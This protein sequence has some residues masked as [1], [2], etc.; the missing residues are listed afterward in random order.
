MPY[1][2]GDMV[3][4]RPDIQA[5]YRYQSPTTG[6]MD[7]Y[8]NEEMANRFGDVAMIVMIM[9]SPFPGYRIRFI[10]E[11]YAN[12][13]AWTDDMLMPHKEISN[14]QAVGIMSLDKDY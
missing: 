12:P 5:G 2:E 3:M 1:K 14:R 10:K 8:C 7:F 11:R 6:R 13:Y 4:V 9:K